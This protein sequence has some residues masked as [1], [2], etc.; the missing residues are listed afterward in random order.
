L[1]WEQKGDFPLRYFIEPV[2][3]T[4]NYAEAAGYA[5]I[6]M[7]GLSGGG[8]STTFAPAVDKRIKRSFP[9]AGSVP[10]AMRNPTGKMPNQTW[11]GSDAED[12][13]QSCMPPD[14]PQRGGDD[15]PGRHAFV[16]C[17]CAPR[18]LPVRPRRAAAFWLVRGP[19]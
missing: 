14:A 17:N 8:W 11:T 13:E 16:S 4:A 18:L 12:Y 15:N 5:E 7:A 3:L 10:C 6:N 9:I 19:T 1:P 2:V